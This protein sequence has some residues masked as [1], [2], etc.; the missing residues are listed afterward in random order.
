M[1]TFYEGKQEAGVFIRRLPIADPEYLLATNNA[2][3]QSAFVF[4]KH[5]RQGAKTPGPPLRGGH[6]IKKV[7]VSLLV[8]NLKHLRPG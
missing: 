8:Q 4:H 7:Q 6:E 3:T 2:H 1:H 5:A